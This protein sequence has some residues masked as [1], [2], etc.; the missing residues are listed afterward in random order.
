MVFIDSITPVVVIASAVLWTKFKG[1]FTALEVFPILSL[2][3]I[4]QGPLFS[5]VSVLSDVSPTLTCIKRVEEYLE[6]PEWNDSRQFASDEESNSQPGEKGAEKDAGSAIELE[7]ACIAPTHS[8]QVALSNISL[9][10]QKSHV[11]PVIGPVGSGKSSFLRALIGEAALKSGQIRIFGAKKIAYCAQVPFL[12]NTTVRQNIVGSDDFD[13][14]LY[15]DVLQACQLVDDLNELPIGDMTIVGSDGMN[16]SVGQ[17]VRVSLAR[18]AFTA[19]D[20]VIIDDV[21]GSLDKKT[22]RAILKSLLGKDGLLRKRQSTV[23]FATHLGDA[24]DVADQVL[25]LDGL[26]GIKPYEKKDFESA[27]FKSTLREAINSP[28]EQCT[29]PTLETIA[30]SPAAPTIDLDDGAARDL[31]VRNETGIY[32]FYFR[33]FPKSRIALFILLMLGLAFFDNFPNGYI[34]LWVDK[35][36]GNKLLLIGYCMFA[37]VNAAVG[38]AG[39]RL[40]YLQLLP[41]SGGNLHQMLLAAT[42]GA[43]YAFICT[44]DSGSLLNRFSQDMNSIVQDLPTA[45]Y[46]FIFMALSSCIEMGFVFAGASYASLAMPFVGGALYF[47]QMYYLRTSRQLRH[48]ELEAKAPLFVYFKETTNGIEHI[49]SFGRTSSQLEQG[50]QLLDASQRAFYQL[51]CV[52]R[53]LLVVLDLTVAATAVVI[54]AIALYV[55][56]SSSAPSIGLSF[57]VL[58]EFGDTL[59]RTVNF[60]TN[61]EISLG[62]ISRIKAFVDSTP[63]EKD[64]ASPAAISEHWPEHGRIDFTNVT[65]RYTTEAVLKDATFTLNAGEKV[66]IQGRSGSGKSTLLLTTLNFLEYDGAV[67]IDGVNIRSVPRQT[68]RERITTIPQLPVVL[69]GSIRDNLTPFTDDPN[70]FSPADLE[71]T[72]DKLGIWTVVRAKGGL[73]APMDSAG[74][75]VAEQQLVCIARAL[76]H[77]KHT[78]SKV[79]IIDEATAT[80]SVAAAKHVQRATG[81]AFKECTVLAVSHWDAAMQKADVNLDVDKGVVTCT[82]TAEEEA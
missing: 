2:V 64:T 74:F 6:L 49:R 66:A 38:L 10:L 8:S 80:L 44:V 62:S 26:Q 18:A 65:S 20:V 50:L 13:E 72:L 55:R 70:A 3:V 14:K 69:A 39:Q 41:H 79:V 4:V 81:E 58:I 67:T 12:S 42:M 11:I 75:S 34:R 27:T 51:C 45:L 21:F 24:I 19:A 31:R 23:I 60:W 78:R 53:W 7:E 77:H 76:L 57:L 9:K 28:D 48:L 22:T 68:L 1:G 46:K 43:T 54:T 30:P 73:D 40:F 29:A 47:I 61:M 52:Q 35:A 59:S 17:Q 32:R 16:L 33:S 71:Y 36:P 5:I 82:R 37:L 56:N 25:L 15:T 63:Q